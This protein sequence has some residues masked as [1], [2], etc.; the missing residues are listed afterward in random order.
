VNNEA[1]LKVKPPEVEMSLK[2]D[3]KYE[4]GYQS[5]KNIQRCLNFEVGQNS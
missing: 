1:H 4:T 5:A 2:D 3:N